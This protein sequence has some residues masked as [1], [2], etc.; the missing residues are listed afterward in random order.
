MMRSTWLAPL[1]FLFVTTIAGL[2]LADVSPGCKCSTPGILEQG[3]VAAAMGLAGV[4]ALML[5]RSRKRS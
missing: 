1:S 2:A 4:G 5:G 3:G